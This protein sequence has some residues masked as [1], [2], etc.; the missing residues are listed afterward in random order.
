LLRKLELPRSSAPRASVIIP[1]TSTPALLRACLA[2]LARLGPDGIPYETIVVLNEP[3]TEIE[4]ELR[5]SVTGV[6]IISSPINLGIAGAG[7]RGRS[8][9]RGE[10]LVTLHDD[11]EVETGWL[12]ALVETADAHQE[13]GAVGGTVLFPDGR[14]Q[15]AGMI[16]WQDA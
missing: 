16:L 5:T 4:A 6:E 14:L 1:A 8:L 3:S 15:N 9:A 7:N 13:A 12:E 11:A 10:F 2:S